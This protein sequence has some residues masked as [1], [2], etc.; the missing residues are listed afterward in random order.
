MPNKFMEMVMAR[1]P[2]AVSELVEM[3]ALIERYG[4]GRVFDV[5]DPVMIARTP[6]MWCGMA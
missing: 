3:Q 1:L 2:I 6:S 5:R 4:I